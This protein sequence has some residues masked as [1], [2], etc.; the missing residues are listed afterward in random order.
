MGW[1]N[2]DPT[3]KIPE[4]R[5]PTTTWVHH[6][7][8][9]ARGEPVGQTRDRAPTGGTTSRDAEGPTTLM[10]ARI[11]TVGEKTT[12]GKGLGRVTRAVTEAE[13][14]AVVMAGAGART[15]T[16]MEESFVAAGMTGL[17]IMGVQ[18]KT[19]SRDKE[20]DVLNRGTAKTLMTRTEEVG[21][22]VLGVTGS[23]TST[24]GRK[25]TLT[26]LTT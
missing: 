20:T 15:S 26:A 2:K 4:V 19:L 18:E 11:S 23:M 16:V 22:V 12:G 6:L 10:A 13:A 9:R 21:R 8:G 17:I 3:A 5:R 14:A 24:A 25:R 1:D 7:I